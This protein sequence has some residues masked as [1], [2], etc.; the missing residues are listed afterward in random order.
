MTSSSWLPSL[1]G[2][3]KGQADPFIAL[4]R[5]MD[6][7]LDGFFKAAPGQF[8]PSVDVSETDKEIKIVAELPGVERKDIDVTLAGNQLTIRG[9]KRSESEEKK[10]A[11]DKSGAQF[12]RVERSFGAFE[13]TLALPF[14]IDP[15]AIAADFKN[16]V[17]TVSVP[18]SAEATARSRKI[19]I[20]AAS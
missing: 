15:A 11:D 19:E 1:F 14:D 18:K 7:V 17:L 20:G 8:L 3:R 2:D 5:Q 6:E 9:E 16:G 4:R 10:A 12:H 13:R